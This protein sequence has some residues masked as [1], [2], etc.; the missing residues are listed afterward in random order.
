MSRIAVSSSRK[1]ESCALPAPAL[2]RPRQRQF[3]AGCETS[4]P[5]LPCGRA[6]TPNLASEMPAPRL[7]ARQSHS[8]AESHS[9]LAIDSANLSSAAASFVACTSL[10]ATLPRSVQSISTRARDARPAQTNS[11]SPRHGSGWPCAPAPARNIRAA[12]T[13]AAPPPVP[14]RRGLPANSSQRIQKSAMHRST[15]VSPSH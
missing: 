14:S 5:L 8:S 7:R 15:P 3:P 12:R 1:T 9:T 10:V 4:P 2:R 13:N 6:Q 11:T